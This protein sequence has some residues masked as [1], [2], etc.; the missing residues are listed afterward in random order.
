MNFLSFIDILVVSIRDGSKILQ[1]LPSNWRMYP[2]LI[3]YGTLI[4]FLLKFCTCKTSLMCFTPFQVSI[5]MVPFPLDL[6]SA[7]FPNP[8]G[9]FT[10]V[11]SWIKS[12]ES[13]AMCYCIY[14]RSTIHW[15]VGYI[16]HTEQVTYFIWNLCLCLIMFPFVIFLYMATPLAMVALRLA[17]LSTISLYVIG[18]FANSSWRKLVF[19][20]CYIFSFSKTRL[21]SAF[22][23]LLLVIL[24]S[25]TCLKCFFHTCLLS[26]ICSFFLSFHHAYHLALI[27]L[28]LLSPLYF[29][30]HRLHY[31]MLL[32]PY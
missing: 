5:A 15:I 24:V 19:L 31:H 29:L 12:D 23:F 7:I 30:S 8:M 13:L 11:S 17:F 27:L 2:F 25:V 10:N 28:E 3:N 20:L 4:K 22:D 14:Y 16:L 32:S 1:V 9:F 21:E 6:T 26:S 18:S